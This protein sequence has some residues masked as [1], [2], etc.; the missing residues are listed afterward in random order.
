MNGLNKHLGA[1]GIRLHVERERWTQD[2][3][4]PDKNLKKY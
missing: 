2:I 1:D 4:M 3:E